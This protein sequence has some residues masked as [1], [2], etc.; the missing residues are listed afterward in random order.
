MVD[1]A[2]PPRLLPGNEPAA[3]QQPPNVACL[4]LVGADG[5]GGGGGWSGDARCPSRWTVPPS[6][7]GWV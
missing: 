3:S 2:T 7:V 4:V 6:W 1:L 5:G